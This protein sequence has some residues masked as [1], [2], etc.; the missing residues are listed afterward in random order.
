MARRGSSL[1]QTGVAISKEINSKYDVIKIVADRIEVLDKL[2]TINLTNFANI[3]ADAID[4]TGIKVE[5]DTAWGAEAVWDPE[6]KILT[7]PVSNGVDGKSAY[8]IAREHGYIGSEEDFN[9]ILGFIDTLKYEVG[10]MRDEVYVTD[11]KAQATLQTLDS[12]YNQTVGDFRIKYTYDEENDL[13]L[14]EVMTGEY[15]LLHYIDEMRDARDTAVA[16]A[17][18]AVNAATESTASRDASVSAKIETL[19]ANDTIQAIFNDFQNLFIGAYEA[20]PALKPNGNPLSAGVIYFNTTTGK[21]Y[22]YEGNAWTLAAFTANDILAQLTNEQVTAAIGFD[23]QQRESREET[24]TNKT[25]SDVSNYVSA[26]NTHIE[27]KANEFITK[28][29]ALAFSHYDDI[30]D[31]IVVKKADN[32]LSDEAFCV[33]TSDLLEGEEGTA[34]VAGIISG[35]DTAGFPEG[36]T[37]YLSTLGELTRIKPTS[38]FEQVMGI[39][40]KTNDINGSIIVLV[41]NKFRIPAKDEIDQLGVDAGTVGGY[42]VESNVPLNAIFT[43]NNYSDEEKA[44]L[45]GLESSRFK[46]LFTSVVDLQT[47]LPVGVSGDYAD[48]D[49]GVGGVVARYIWD[50]SNTQWSA[51]QGES[52]ALTPAQVKSLYEANAETEVFTTTEKDKLALV[53]ANA[54]NYSLPVASNLISGGIRIGSGLSIVNGL[55]GVNWSSASGVPWEGIANRPTDL[56]DFTNSPNF[57]NES[58]L[59]NYTKVFTQ[60]EKDK[61]E[62]LQ[63]YTPGVGISID[64]DVISATGGGTADSIDWTNVLNTPN[65]IAGYG[66]GADLASYLGGNGYLTSVSESDVTQHQ[67]ALELTVSQIVDL[68]TTA[69]G[70]LI[71]DFIER[72]VITFVN[73]VATTTAYSTTPTYSGFHTSTVWIIASDANFT[74][75]VDTVESSGVLTSYLPSGLVGGNTYYIK[76][77]HKS[78][79]FGSIF[80]EPVLFIAATTYIEQPVVTTEIITD[81][82]GV[83]GILDRPILEASAF[84]IINDPGSETHVSTTWKAFNLNTQSYDYTNIEDTVNLTSIQIPAGVLQTSTTYRFSATYHTVNRASNDGVVEITTFGGFVEESH[85]LFADHNVVPQIYTKDGT[86]FEEAFESVSGSYYNPNNADIDCK[87]I[88]KSVSSKLVAFGFD[89]VNDY[90]VAA[91][92]RIFNGT[93]GEITFTTLA[94]AQTPLGAGVLPGTNTMAICG[95]NEDVLVVIKSNGDL[96]IYGISQTALTKIIEFTGV[97]ANSIG[98]NT[99]G[100]VVLIATDSGITPLD[101]STPQTPSLGATF[102]M[103]AGRV[104]MYVPAHDVF[105]CGN[106]NYTK[107]LHVDST[108]FE[109]TDKTGTTTSAIFGGNSGVAL[110]SSDTIIEAKYNSNNLVYK[111]Q[112]VPSVGDTFNTQSVAITVTASSAVKDIHYDSNSKTLITTGGSGDVHIHDEDAAGNFTLIT[113]NPEGVAIDKFNSVTSNAEGVKIIWNLKG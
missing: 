62:L 23:L 91:F 53:E 55:A 5:T 13:I 20:P 19:F 90:N 101:I 11:K 88:T 36:S 81:S 9:L 87:A 65:T 85:L 64:G 82:F 75:I 42:T 84:S 103:A 44:K 52:T 31:K 61:L 95:E 8:D 56:G 15:S 43:D 37:L 30:N 63:N 79:V 24:L 112:V 106:L 48:V 51:V 93:T 4:F 98:I 110:Y 34:I 77:S 33:A 83:T 17:T 21:V 35:I 28:G 111:T 22:M 59:L 100:T 12:L 58:A 40:L 60:E 46:G 96:A 78:G 92:R 47:Q 49:E 94:Y 18:T 109:I 107:V 50:E 68:N 74:N 66:I 16:S 67:E 97:N 102:V 108:T 32:T 25:I 57:L 26:D 69:A 76:A 54:N 14:S 38:G 71:A 2:N 10:V 113:P 7:V 105:L 104:P 45:A 27:I 70:T 6:T 89:S 3:L 86:A 99:D 39:T 72:P 80:S 1:T 29:N 73:G 41:K